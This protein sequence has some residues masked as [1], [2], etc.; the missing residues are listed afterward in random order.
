MA[1][2][3]IKFEL[4]VD[5]NDLEL[6]AGRLVRFLFFQTIRGS[7]Q[8]HITAVDDSWSYYDGFYKEDAE[9]V[10][11]FGYTQDGAEVWS[12]EHHLVVGEVTAEYDPDGIDVT[13]SGLDKG[14][15]IFNTCSQKVFKDKLISEMVKDLAEANGLDVSVE[16]TKNKTD[17][18]QGIMPDGHFIQKFLLPRAYNETRQDYLCWIRNGDT[19]VFEPPEVSS[20]QATFD[21]PGESDDY[22]PE[23]PLQCRY[24]PIMMRPNG[25][26]STQVRGVDP[27]KKEGLFFTADDN[28]VSYRKLANTGPNAPDMPSRIVMLDEVEDKVVTNIGKALWSTKSRELWL[29]DT[30]SALSPKIEVGRPI[31]LNVTKSDSS[32]HFTSGKYLLAGVMH[33]IDM[34]VNES[35][36]RFWLCRRTKQ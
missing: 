31:Q 14:S 3:G 13:V 30:K 10:L 2:S 12:P 7:A 9:L 4:R 23:A 1:D 21:F 33:W 25:A 27:L 22:Q 16:A 26:W 19:L 6:E 24:R 28:T 8:Y 36:T 5:G 34:T 15:L 29:V 17:I 18:T 32:S 35:F 20:P 11:R